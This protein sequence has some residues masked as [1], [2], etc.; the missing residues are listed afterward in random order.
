MASHELQDPCTSYP[1]GD[2]LGLGVNTTQSALGFPKLTSSSAI[3]PRSVSV[4]YTCCNG[5]IEVI[6]LEISLG[7]AHLQI[8]RLG[9]ALD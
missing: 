9:S 1:R 3:T 2:S 4:V 5:E 8:R 7:V 6:C